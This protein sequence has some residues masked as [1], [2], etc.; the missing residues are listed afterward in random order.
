MEAIGDPREGPS[1][2][3]AFEEQP[4]P[5]WTEQVTLRAVVASVA[6]GAVFS[7]VMMNL[8]FTSGIIP[9]LNVSAGLLGFF[10]LKAW[11]RLLDQLGVSYSPFTRHENAVIQTC[12]VACASMTYSGT[13]VRM[14]H[15]DATSTMNPFDR[16]LDFVRACIVV[17]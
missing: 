12:V 8:V 5:P 15:R 16:Y 13:H 14:L 11:T 1:T 4:I 17:I 6:L 2:E 7:G 9:T 3:R 10:L